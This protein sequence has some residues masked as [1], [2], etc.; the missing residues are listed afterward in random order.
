VIR[1]VENV[2]P[3]LTNL[4]EQDRQNVNTAIRE[5]STGQDVNQLSD[6]PSA[7]A[8]LVDNRAETAAVDQFQHSITTIQG[9]LQT[10]DSA[11]NSV[12]QDLTQAIALGTEG[13]NGTLSSAE[14]NA[15]A[16]QV[17][18]LQQD[19]LGLANATYQGSYIFAGTAVTTAPYV[20]DSTSPSGVRYVGNTKVNNVEVGL[21]QSVPVNLP[22]S[23]IFN[24]AGADVFQALHDLTTALQTNGN[25]PAATAEVKS[26]FDN[27]SQQ[28][29]FYGATLQRLNAA[30]SNLS[31][32]AV[33]LA[34]IQ[35]DLIS[36]DPAQAASD[37]SQ[38][39]TT[40]DATL[41][42]FGKVTQNTLMDYIR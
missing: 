10:A 23:T 33:T 20:V 31:Q 11:L 21:G 26:A 9:R 7:A 13:A 37:L 28:R 17:T 5:I 19:V 42:A 14:R 6:N 3:T 27:I 29:T 35:N 38:A 41:A 15:V 24:G 12:I 2:F 36:A 18:N 25:I 32:E 40:L 4:I 22:G 39:V 8:L 16:Q 34:T 1:I 30:S